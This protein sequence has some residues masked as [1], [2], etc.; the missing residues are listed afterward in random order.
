MKLSQLFLNKIIFVFKKIYFTNNFSDKTSQ[1][2]LSNYKI[3]NV[4]NNCSFD[5]N[6][7]FDIITKL[8][9]E[10]SED[11]QK[12]KTE[13]K[14]Y[15]LWWGREGLQLKDGRISIIERFEKKTSTMLPSY[16]I[17]I[18]D[19]S[20][21]GKKS[22][23]ENH[24]RGGRGDQVL[25]RYSH[26]TKTKVENKSYS[27]VYKDKEIE[28]FIAY[29]KEANV[30]YKTLIFP[31]MGSTTV[32]IYDKKNR[33]IIRATQNKYTYGGK[34]NLIELKK[35][36]YDTSIFSIENTKEDVIGWLSAQEALKITKET[37]GEKIF[38]NYKN[39]RY[40]EKL[41]NFI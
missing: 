24:I 12:F 22:L 37:M 23:N 16:I 9:I 35:Q 17:K 33:E 11:V 18:D 30:P 27:Y 15:T 34:D 19:Y 3:K 5:L 10:L 21:A 26:T 13:C 25:C 40:S 38:L 14:V 28:K 31:N 29:L 20:K 4:E 8:S 32:I 6:R 36:T 41:M 7:Y 39:T 1:R 2:M